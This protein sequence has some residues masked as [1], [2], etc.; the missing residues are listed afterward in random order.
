[1][2]ETFGNLK[3]RIEKI[4]SKGR[5]A[6]T[7]SDLTRAAVLVPI[8]FRRG[9]PGLIVTKR[10]MNVAKHKGQISFPGG[11]REPEDKDEIE[12]A[13]REAKEEIGIDPSS[14]TVAGVL[15]DYATTTGFAV[16]PVVGFVEPNA[17]LT[18]D[19]IEVSEIIEVPLAALREPSSHELVTVEYGNVGYRYHRYSVG[20]NIIW[21]ATAGI[22][23]HFLSVLDGE[24]SS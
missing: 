14:I 7:R 20:D 10:T 9:E 16:T 5:T 17:V 23:H 8:V 21:G 18:P 2:D 11:M 12:N 1:M 22:I 4:A 24:E 15:D 19:P 6:I 3:S 13:L